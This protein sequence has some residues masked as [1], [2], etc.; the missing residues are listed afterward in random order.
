[1]KKF[2]KG[3]LSAGTHFSYR[4]NMIRVD[5]NYVKKWIQFVKTTPKEELANLIS[6]TILDEFET[7]LPVNDDSDKDIACSL[8]VLRRDR[9]FS[10]AFSSYALTHNFEVQFKKITNGILKTYFNMINEV[11]FF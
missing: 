6:K 11:I 2:V 7:L 10:H 9:S 8:Q 1:M 3:F 5:E 4:K